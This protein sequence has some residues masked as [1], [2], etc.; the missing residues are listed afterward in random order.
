MKQSKHRPDMT[1]LDQR[2]DNGQ[3]AVR[4][5]FLHGKK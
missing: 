4:G 1:T 5:T 3:L 2:Q